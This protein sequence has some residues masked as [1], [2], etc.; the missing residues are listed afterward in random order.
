MNALASPEAAE[1][2]GREDAR[3]AGLRWV[4]DRRPGL[5]RKKRGGGFAYVRSDGSRVPDGPDLV[6]I[7]RLAI[8]P[9]WTD[10]W[11]CA[12]SRGH[13]QATGRDARGR[14]QYRY[15][16]R[17]S[18]IRDAN[19]FDRIVAF[20]RSL[21]ES[22]GAAAA[23]CGAPAYLASGSLRRSCASSTSP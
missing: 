21:P 9:A 6:R 2:A 11:I 7:E 19:K 20:G 18:D 5:R 8:P 13:L 1:Q 12:D 3:A 10:V 17:W 16:A 4:T 22:D 15:H 14:K 23:T